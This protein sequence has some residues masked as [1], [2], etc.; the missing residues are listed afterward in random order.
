MISYL[1]F[2]LDYLPWET[3]ISGLG[4]FTDLLY[5]TNLFDSYKLY[6]VNLIKPLYNKLGWEDKE[7][8]GNLDKYNLFLYN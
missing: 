7:N 4:F 5:S 8:D 1:K 2:E 6:L 3:A